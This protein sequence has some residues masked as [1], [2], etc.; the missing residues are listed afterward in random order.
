MVSMILDQWI[1]V[2]KSINDGWRVWFPREKCLP[3]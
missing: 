2:G 1:V 3:S